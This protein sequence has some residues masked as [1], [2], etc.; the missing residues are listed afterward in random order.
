VITYRFPADETSLIPDIPP[1][2]HQNKVHPDAVA[3]IHHFANCRS[4]SGRSSQ[5]L[6]IAMGMSRD[7]DEQAPRRHLKQN[8]LHVRAS[9]NRAKGRCAISFAGVGWTRK[10]DG[11][12]PSFAR[13]NSRTCL[14]KT[15]RRHFTK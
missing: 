1:T 3:K 15:H 6:D 8:S 2:D 11:I 10:G 9:R 14:H 13:A 5:A 12:G 4:L 7:E